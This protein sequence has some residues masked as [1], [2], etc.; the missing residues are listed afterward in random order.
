LK[1]HEIPLG[2]RIVS[3]IDAFDAM[4]S[5][6]PYRFGIS[7]EEAILRLVQA[8]GARFDREVVKAFTNVLRADSSRILY[9]L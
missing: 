4:V 9:R 7:E 5:S 2:T 3:V 1:D 8:G 6:R